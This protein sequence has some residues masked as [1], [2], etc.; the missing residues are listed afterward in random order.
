MSIRLLTRFFCAGCLILLLVVFLHPSQAQLFAPDDISSS[1]EITVPTTKSG[2]RSKPGDKR[3]E[4]RGNLKIPTT[5]AIPAN[6]GG[7]VWLA[8]GP[9]PTIDGQVEN[10]SPNDE[11]VGAIHT[12]LAHP[13]DPDVLYAGGTNGGIWKTDN[14]TAASPFWSPLID[15]QASLSIGALEFDPTDITHETLVAGIGRYSSFGQVGGARTGLLKTIDS[16]VN[17]TAITDMETRNISGVAP[18]GNT[19]VA[20]VNIA[21]AFTCG[22]VGLWRSTDG[23]TNFSKLSTV[24]GV[25]DGVAFDLASDPSN[26]AVLYTGITFAGFCTGDTLFNGIYKSTN[27]GASWTK[28]SN[29]AM[30][31]LIVD[32]DTNN[33]EI[34]TDGSNVY[35][36]IIQFGQTA[37][38]FHSDDSGGTWTAMDLPV[39]PQTAAA[40]IS[41][42]V[43]GTP[44]TINTGVGHGLVTGNLVE[45][46]GVTGTTG[47]NG[48]FYVT[49][50]GGTTYTLNGSS[51]PNVYTGGGSW[52]KLSGLNP[53]H[54]PGSQGA[55]HAAIRI[56][57][58]TGTMVYIGGDRQDLPFPNFI[59]ATDFTGNL[60]RGDTTIV[61]TN[62]AP[63]PQWE[64]L[65]HSDSVVET[66][67]GGTANSS[68]PHADA[69]EMVFDANGDLI[70]G[71]DG[72]IYRRT[73]P[74]DNTG[75][76][77]S[78]NGNLQ[79]TE[80]HDVAYDSVSNIIISG[81]QDTGTTQ[82]QS[83]LSLTWD[84]V[85]TADGGD[86]AVDDTS[87]PNMSVRYSSFQNLGFFRRRTYD[88][89]NVLQSEIFPALNVT[90]G[91]ALQVQ[92]L[93]PVELNAIDQ[94]RLV[95]GG[96]NGVYE[97][98][99]QGGNIR[100][101]TGTGADC[102]VGNSITTLAYGGESGGIDNEEVLY[103]GVGSDVFVRTAA[104]PTPLSQAVTYPGINSIRDIVMDPDDLNTAFVIDSFNVFM[105]SN[106]GASWTDITGNLMDTQ[107]RSLTFLPG[108]TDRIA[109]GTRNGVFVQDLPLVAPFNNWGQLG[110]G[111]PNAPVW[112]MEYDAVDD[113]FIVGTMGRGAW[114]LQE[115][116]T[117]GLPDNL[118]LRNEILSASRTDKACTK[119]EIGPVFTVSGDS[120]QHDVVAGSMISIKP[121]FV[122]KT[123]S[124]F[125]ASIDPGVSP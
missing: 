24:Q 74:T 116:G 94:T 16:G 19:I 124:Q 107:F 95:I 3:Q 14:A 69:R 88:A 45:I 91:S 39:V 75:D 33:I 65:T 23:G 81:N 58:T 1:T 12:V 73:S 60:S 49:V 47:A 111:L 71:D 36:N 123:G 101:I 67:A 121:G 80:M 30:D 43:P 46:T 99:D 85:S 70:E 56:D 78:I 21:D 76:W 37:G 55:I 106:T 38:I 8:H 26:N 90:S 98:L 2:K 13:T 89:S 40:A 15:Q 42:L 31:A 10:I 29:A 32:G 122:V 11:V 108:T 18:R 112:D 61:P 48:V 57:P 7:G 84:S 102:T 113:L 66:P 97:S 44:I 54:K 20:S 117:C 119:I 103:A 114:Q 6:I 53:R 125:N 63:S 59:G 79:T 35:V 27:T 17:W 86:V 115:N 51:D 77:F 50:T 5:N 105:T 9:G 82:Q 68:A 72:G 4:S 41:G 83:P 34:D 109:V 104:F 118:L 93:T 28:V 22:N 110:T 96:C 100:E 120:T 52:S 87:T 25:P 62:S 92:F 64:H